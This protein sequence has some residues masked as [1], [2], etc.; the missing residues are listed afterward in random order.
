MNSSKE[1]KISEQGCIL[2]NIKAYHRLWLINKT[3]FLIHGG[4][5]HN[6]FWHI[7]RPKLEVVLYQ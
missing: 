3:T 5:R 7:Y 2:S 6:R 4:I 1:V